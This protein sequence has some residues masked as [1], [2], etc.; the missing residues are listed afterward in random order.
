M[1]DLVDRA[2]IFARKRHEGQTRKG[3]ANEPY[4][5]HLAEVADFV[6]RHGADNITIAAAWLHD[7]VEDCDDTDF[8][9]LEGLFGEEVT[10][11]VREMTDDKSLPKE[12]R[13]ELQ[14][15]DASEKSPRAAVLKLGDKT[16]NVRGIGMSR[17]ANWSLERCRA[18]LDWAEAVVD[19]LPETPSA[20]MAEF[21]TTL[22][23]SR[24]ALSSSDAAN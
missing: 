18:Y 10:E 21:R 24:G 3:A 22:A 8:P 5:D 16:S 23:A 6:T 1:S 11:I 14:I 13:K 20:A 12:K 17:P 19:R 2:E 9:E 15:E 4:A 7:T